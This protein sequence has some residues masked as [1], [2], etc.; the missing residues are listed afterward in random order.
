M[1]HELAAA[2]IGTVDTIIEA[3]K[4]EG[5]EKVLEDLHNSYKKREGTPIANELVYKEFLEFLKYMSTD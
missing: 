4:R 3:I 1:T 5:L 2:V